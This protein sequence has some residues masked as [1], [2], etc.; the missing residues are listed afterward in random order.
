MW[1]LIH[2]D[3]MRQPS[4]DTI[5]PTPCMLPSTLG[6]MMGAK[7]SEGGIGGSNCSTMG[8]EISLAE[9]GSKKATL[10]QTSMRPQIA[11]VVQRI[12]ILHFGGVVPY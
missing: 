12:Y 6:L 4:V 3:S 5:R 11:S 2:V 1:R 9:L 10:P 8:S 7:A